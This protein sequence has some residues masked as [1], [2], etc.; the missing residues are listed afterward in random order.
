MSRVGGGLPVGHDELSCVPPQCNPRNRRTFA[1]TET[2]TE[3]SCYCQLGDV[4]V[5]RVK[6]FKTW[7]LSTHHCL[8]IKYSGRTYYNIYI[9]IYGNLRPSLNDG[10]LNML[11]VLISKGMDYIFQNI[12][13]H[14]F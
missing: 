1:P 14:M 13:Q 5:R 3:T 11:I 6:N 9:Y 12:K 10:S 4:Q 2:E 7:C 8:T